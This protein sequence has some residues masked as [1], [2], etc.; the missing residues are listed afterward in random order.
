MDGRVV[1]YDDNIGRGLIESSSGR[2]TVEAD[3]MATDARVE[4]A[5]VHFDLQRGDPH[6]R[7]VNVE[8]I[9]SRRNSPTQHR[10]GHTA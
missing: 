10:F 3:D 7:A 2:F 5:R 9:E 6:D 8:L 1:N 4:G